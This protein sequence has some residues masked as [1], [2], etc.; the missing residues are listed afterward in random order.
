MSPHTQAGHQ[1]S[2][3]TLHQVSYTSVLQS[4]YSTYTWNWFHFNLSFQLAVTKP[5]QA[6]AGQAEGEEDVGGLLC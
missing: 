2:A 3:R 1:A 4:Y 6:R 5:D